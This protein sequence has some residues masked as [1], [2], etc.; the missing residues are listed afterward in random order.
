VAKKYYQ[1]AINVENELKAANKRSVLPII[2]TS[3]MK[4]SINQAKVSLKKIK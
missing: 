1:K 4:S 3:T 2:E